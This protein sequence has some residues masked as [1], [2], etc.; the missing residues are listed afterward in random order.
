ML[1]R[2][3]I[4]G[5]TLALLT[6]MADAK[7]PRPKKAK[8]TRGHKAKWGPAKVKVKSKNPKR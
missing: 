4:L 3:L 8:I 2:S 1:F 7:I 5:L 6:P